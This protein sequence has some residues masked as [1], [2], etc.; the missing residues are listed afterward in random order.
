MTQEPK[1][2]LIVSANPK[3]TLP[4]HLGEERKRIKEGLRAASNRENFDIEISEASTLEIFERDMMEYKPNILHFC[5]HGYGKNGIVFESSIGSSQIVDG[6]SLAKFLH[7]FETHLECVILNACYSEIQAN[8]IRKYIKYVVGMSDQISDN[9]AIAFSTSF[10]QALFANSTYDKAFE[11]ACAHL[12]MIGISDAVLEPKLFLRNIIDSE[13]TSKKIELYLK[14]LKKGCEDKLTEIR[15]GIYNLSGNVFE[16]ENRAIYGADDFDLHVGYQA[17]D[18]NGG[19]SEKTTDICKCI[20]S[21]DRKIILL[22]EPGSGKSVSLLKMTIEFAQRALSDEEAL[23]P[24]LI[25][26][27]SYKESIEP[28]EYVKKRM[29]I[30][31]EYV[32]EIF[33]PEKCIFVFDALNEVAS[34]KKNLL[35]IILRH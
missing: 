19:I 29:S 6:E 31:T 10:Y 11:I 26:L 33:V 1:K 23:I 9:T 3:N 13:S 34:G 17:F 14:K 22:G 18:E 25:P 28:E 8:E 2:I 21:S 24:I 4:L 5:G 30:D 15:S 7:L 20:N 16:E 12:H 35:L 27:G 32:D